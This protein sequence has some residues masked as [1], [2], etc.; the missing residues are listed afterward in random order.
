MHSSRPSDCC[1]QPLPENRDRAAKT[2]P[3]SFRPDPAMPVS[4]SSLYTLPS[5]LDEN[6]AIPRVQASPPVASATAV[7]RI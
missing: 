6:I 1:G 5:S 3:D 2:E 4:F 7:L